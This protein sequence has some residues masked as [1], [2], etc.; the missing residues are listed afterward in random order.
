M[1]PRL[2]PTHFILFL[3]LAT[4]GDWR[5][6]L[7]VGSIAT[8]QTDGYFGLLPHDSCFDSPCT[9]KSFLCVGLLVWFDGSHCCWT[10]EG[11][12]S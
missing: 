6:L 2:R 1:W 11:L 12:S 8:T 7:W 10:L 9:P 5:S 4:D 3:F